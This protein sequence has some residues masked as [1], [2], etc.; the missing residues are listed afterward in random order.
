[1]DQ[2][3]DSDGFDLRKTQLGL[4]IAT[5]CQRHL[6]LGQGFRTGSGSAPLRF[7]G[8]HSQ[9]R[10]DSALARGSCFQWP[11]VAFEVA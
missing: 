6:E 11:M 4:V 7:G 10:L 3:F 8:L 2:Q 1:M 9:A 5:D